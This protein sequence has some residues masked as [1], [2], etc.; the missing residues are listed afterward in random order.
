MFSGGGVINDSEGECAN[1]GLI[2]FE[3]MAKIDVRISEGWEVNTHVM[4]VTACWISGIATLESRSENLTNYCRLD[5]A[6]MQT[7][8]QKGSW[9][10]C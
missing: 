8:G 2:G 10:R 5:P 3:E 9:S 6:P 1:A 4:T 7:R